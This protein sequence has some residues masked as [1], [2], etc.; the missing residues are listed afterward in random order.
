MAAEIGALCA[1]VRAA[2]GAARAAGVDE[3]LKYG[4]C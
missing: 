1:V 2:C 3:Y 4:D